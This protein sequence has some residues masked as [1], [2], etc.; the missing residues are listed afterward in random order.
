MH[1]RRG[2]IKYEAGR[3]GENV[4]CLADVPSHDDVLV[5]SRSTSM[6]HVVAVVLKRLLLWRRVQTWSLAL[7]LALVLQREKNV[8]D[9]LLTSG[10]G[11][12]TLE[13]RGTKTP[14]FDG[15]QGTLEI[16]PESTGRQVIRLIESVPALLCHNARSSA[17]RARTTSAYK[18]TNLWFILVKHVLK[19]E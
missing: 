17:P 9:V 4:S 15:A 10:T 3:V 14:G 7:A 5:V 2:T 11:K 8:F 19:L 16:T 1:P 13:G 18:K 12:C 6:P